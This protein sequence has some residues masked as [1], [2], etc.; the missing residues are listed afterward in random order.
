MLFY[1]SFIFST[2]FL[3][4]SINFTFMYLKLHIIIFRIFF[5]HIHYTDKYQT[6]ILMR[7]SFILQLYTYIVYIIYIIYIPIR[8]HLSFIFYFYKRLKIMRL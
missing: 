2:I 7:F 3:G 4:D 1:V 8:F 6:L 5:Q